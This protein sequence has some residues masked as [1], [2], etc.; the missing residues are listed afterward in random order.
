MQSVFFGAS[1]VFG[2]KLH[3][4][5]VNF[6]LPP[7]VTPPAGVVVLTDMP[8]FAAQPDVQELYSGPSG[9]QL[10]PDRGDLLPQIPSM[11]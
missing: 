5:P 2:G 9:K 8:I 3:A 4:P 6:I 1:S 11:P 10:N 7:Y